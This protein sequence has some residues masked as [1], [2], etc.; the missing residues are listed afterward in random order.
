MEDDIERHILND[1]PRLEQVW[2][3]SVILSI[4]F[5]CKARL[6]QVRLLSLIWSLLFV[7]KAGLEPVRLSIHFFIVWNPL[8]EQVKLAKF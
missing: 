2:L 4:L 3:L 5:V 1:K 6:E 8:L 7:C